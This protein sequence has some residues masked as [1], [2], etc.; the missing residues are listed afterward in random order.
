[1]NTDEHR[2]KK[3]SK[4]GGR[5]GPPPTLLSSYLCSSVFICG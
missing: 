5:G 1:M 2:W 3:E 4:S